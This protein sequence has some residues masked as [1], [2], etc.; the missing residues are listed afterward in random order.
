MTA[1]SPPQ[2][3]TATVEP[4]VEAER[5]PLTLRLIGVLLQK[6]PVCRLWVLTGVAAWFVL[7][8]HLLQNASEFGALVV[9]LVG[10]AGWLGRW[11]RAVHVTLAVVFW[12]TIFPLGISEPVTTYGYG[13]TTVGGMRLES[14]ITVL[15]L[16]V[17]A[18][19]HWHYLAVVQAAVYLPTMSGREQ[20]WRRPAG[21]LHIHQWRRQFWQAATAMILALVLQWISATI[22]LDFWPDLPD[23]PPP[24]LNRLI[25]VTAVVALV[26]GSVRLI[27]GLHR[28]RTMTSDEAAMLLQDQAWCELHREW[29]RVAMGHQD[30]PQHRPPVFNQRG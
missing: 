21:T 27:L 24:W 8:L 22:T 19:S 13:P 3:S 9:L 15:A 4:L 6:Y 17:Y 10:I 23:W 1:H 16:I 25:I 18:H 30:T 11:A 29:R 20:P 14:I 5:H 7:I 28:Q 12:L 26:V 2:L